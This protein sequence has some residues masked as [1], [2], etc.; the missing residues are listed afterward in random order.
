VGIGF[1]AFLLMVIIVA[2]LVALTVKC[3]A[4]RA[5]LIKFKN[6]TLWNPIIKGFQVSFITTC[7][8]AFASIGVELSQPEL[9]PKKIITPLVIVSV[10]T[11]ATIATYVAMKLLDRSRLQLTSFIKKYGALYENLDPWHNSRLY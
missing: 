1:V 9:N 8:A 6:K 4:F 5:R 7:F 2:A 3:P 10:M 11:L